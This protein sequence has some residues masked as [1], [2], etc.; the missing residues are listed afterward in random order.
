M[1]TGTV[2]SVWVLFGM[3][4]FEDWMFGCLDHYYYY[5]YFIV[6]YL[7]CF[8]TLHRFWLIILFFFGY[9]VLLDV[10]YFKFGHII[11]IYVVKV[12]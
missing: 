3:V 7:Y 8:W 5:Y 11:W 12:G 1:V 6:C 4:G 2:W 9:Y 10:L